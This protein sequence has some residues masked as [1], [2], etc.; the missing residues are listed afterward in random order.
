MRWIDISYKGE[1][2]GSMLMEL[3][4]EGMVWKGPEL[5]DGY[6]SPARLAW[7]LT[8]DSA[9]GVEREAALTLV[10]KLAQLPEGAMVQVA[11]RLGGALAGKAAMAGGFGQPTGR[12]G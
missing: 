2:I 5:T 11:T 3:S 1:K 12:R 6:H 7:K 9:L 4:V 8:R 10:G